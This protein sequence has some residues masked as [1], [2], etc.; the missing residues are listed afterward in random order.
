MPYSFKGS[1]SFGLVYIPITLHTAVRNNDI[2]FNML[3]KNTMS[4]VQY[5]KTCVDC[6]DHEVKNEDIIKG[7]QYEE[8]KYVVFEDDDFEKLK[9]KKDKNITIEQFVD[10]SDIDPIYFEKSYYVVP[11]GAERAFVLLRGAMENQNKVGIAKTVLGTKETLIAIRVRGGEMLL[12]T[13]YFTDEIQANPIRPSLDVTVN[14]QELDLAKTIINNMTGKF[15]PDKYKDEYRLRIQQAIEQKIAGQ[16]IVRPAEK[17]ETGITNLMDALTASLR[18]TKPAPKATPAR[19]P[20]A[21][22]AAEKPTAIQ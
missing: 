5:K 14:P 12:S 15:E 10:L 8:N 19:K 17:A 22:P 6:N 1:I 16:E 11:T 18:Q 20:R 9:T 2:G 21:R 13:M 4:R 7:Y 3:E